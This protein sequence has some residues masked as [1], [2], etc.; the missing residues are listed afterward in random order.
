M[1]GKIATACQRVSRQI[2]SH[3]MSLRT[4]LSRLPDGQPIVCVNLHGQLVM[5]W[6]AIIAVFHLK[7]PSDSLVYTYCLMDNTLNFDI[8][9]CLV[10]IQ[11]ES[12]VVIWSAP[13]LF[14]NLL[15]ASC[16]NTGDA[17]LRK[18]DSSLLGAHQLHLTMWGNL[19][20]M[21][22]YMHKCTQFNNLTTC[23][24][25]IFHQAD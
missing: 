6:Y 7:H 20:T 10:M 19:P 17:D 8:W 2:P 5:W 11:G 9:R 1:V 16:P 25:Y 3:I 18:P 14:V 21:N 4:L 24:S 15:A 23:I 13:H 22:C 12:C